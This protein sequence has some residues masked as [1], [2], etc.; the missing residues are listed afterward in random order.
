MSVSSRPMGAVG[1]QCVDSTPEAIV[2]ALARYGTV[3][4][5]VIATGQ[6]DQLLSKVD[7]ISRSIGEMHILER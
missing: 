6:L 3:E 4:R 2:A 5:A 7:V 1:T